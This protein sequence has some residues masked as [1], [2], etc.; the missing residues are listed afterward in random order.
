[1]SLT[2]EQ[3]AVMERSVE[4]FLA[5]SQNHDPSFRKDQARAYT[6]GYESGYLARAEVAAA[7]REQLETFV[8]LARR[9][10]EEDYNADTTNIRGAIDDAVAKYDAILAPRETEVQREKAE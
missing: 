1:M 9:L 7:E 5:F 8:R 3:K 10:Q 6:S 2:P 4:A